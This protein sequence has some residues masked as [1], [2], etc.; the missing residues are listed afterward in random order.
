MALSFKDEQTDRLARELARVTGE[1]LTAAVSKAIAERL[2][3]ERRR[4]GG[5]A[6]LRERLDAI[7]AE[8]G[9]L[10]DLDTRTPDEIIGY[11]DAGVPR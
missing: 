6:P 9:A 8:C 7:A 1:T 2:D 10:P 3:R 4:H 5:G 11:D